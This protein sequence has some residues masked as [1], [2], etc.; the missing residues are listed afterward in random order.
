MR[1]MVLGTPTGLLSFRRYQDLGKGS[2]HFCAK[3]L[4]MRGSAVCISDGMGRDGCIPK[5]ARTF[6]NQSKKPMVVMG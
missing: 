6:Q 2:W 3:D 4:L 1:L 5:S